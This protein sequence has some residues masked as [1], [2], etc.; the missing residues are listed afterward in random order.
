MSTKPSFTGTTTTAGTRDL[1]DHA[2]NL[3]KLDFTEIDSYMK[4]MI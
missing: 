2:E 1:R 4:E 3:K